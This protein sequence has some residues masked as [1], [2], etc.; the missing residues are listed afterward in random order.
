MSSQYTHPWGLHGVPVN[1]LLRLL[2]LKELVLPQFEAAC[3]V[4]RDVKN[5]SK[6]LRHDIWFKMDGSASNIFV[7]QAV[8]VREGEVGGMFSGKSNKDFV[9]ALENLWGILLS[10]AGVHMPGSGKVEKAGGGG[11]AAEERAQSET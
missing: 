8:V 7:A 2:Q 9:G 6:P 5:K 3:L 11:G 1:D 10:K 4:N